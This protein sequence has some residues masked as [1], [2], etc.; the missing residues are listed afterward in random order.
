MIELPTPH[1]VT[2]YNGVDEKPER[3]IMKLSD[4]FKKAEQDYKLEL[5]VLVL[6]INPGY[7]E[8]LMRNCKTLGDYM[9]YVDTVRTYKKEYSL[10]EAVER[11]IKECMDSDV[12]ADFLRANQREAKHVSIYGFQSP[13]CRKYR[14]SG[15]FLFLICY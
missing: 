15:L 5:E 2:F 11:A 7:N 6:N 12:L 9:T 14:H 10:E 4:S 8:E 3:Q 13:E 1:F